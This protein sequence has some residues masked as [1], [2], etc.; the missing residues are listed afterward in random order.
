VSYAGRCKFRRIHRRGRTN[1]SAVRASGEP[2]EG[3]MTSPNG[4]LSEKDGG[5]MF[6]VIRVA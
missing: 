3:I 4:F 1:R 5:S 6:Y 2:L